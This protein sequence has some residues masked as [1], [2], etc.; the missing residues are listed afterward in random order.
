ML[1]SAPLPALSAELPSV[2]TKTGAV[3]A[4]LTVN[5]NTYNNVQDA[6]N[7]ANTTVSSTDGFC[8]SDTDQ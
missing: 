2:D 5:G 1:T 3:K 4:G 8:Q 7:A 6:V